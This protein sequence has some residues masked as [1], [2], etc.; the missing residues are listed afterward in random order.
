MNREMI[1]RQTDD[2]D[3]EDKGGGGGD[4]NLCLKVTFSDRADLAGL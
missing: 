2:V 3:D 1:E 4:V